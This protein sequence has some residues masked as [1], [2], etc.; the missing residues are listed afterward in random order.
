M[1]QT[2]LS[3][4]KEVTPSQNNKPRKTLRRVTDVKGEL[5]KPS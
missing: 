3:Q 2:H 5:K 4:D 1:K